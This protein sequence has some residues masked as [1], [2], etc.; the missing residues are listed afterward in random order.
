MHRAPPNTNA[1]ATPWEG[2]VA[3]RNFINNAQQEDSLSGGEPQYRIRSWEDLDSY[4]ERL[5]TVADY[6][7]H[8]LVRLGW[9]GLKLEL[10]MHV[11][12]FDNLVADAEDFKLVCAAL[13]SVSTASR[14]ERRAA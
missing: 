11:A 3:G 7:D 9:A 2:G 10:G 4:T 5:S 14:P 12:E 8:L 1:N 6:R 13:I